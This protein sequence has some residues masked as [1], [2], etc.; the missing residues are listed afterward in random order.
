LV[1]RFA[2]NMKPAAGFKSPCLYS[3]AKAPEPSAVTH[4][5]AEF[6]NQQE[7]WE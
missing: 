4:I 7:S 2:H 3:L 1:Q 6:F 5:R